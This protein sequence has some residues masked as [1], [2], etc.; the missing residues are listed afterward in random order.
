MRKYKTSVLCLLKKIDNNTTIQTSENIEI[1][2]ISRIFVELG[3]P[4]ADSAGFENIC[5]EFFTPLL[6]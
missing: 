4:N 6:V 3:H 5:L 1:R 2:K